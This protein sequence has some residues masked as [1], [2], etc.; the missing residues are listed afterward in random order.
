MS[1][2]RENPEQAV[3]ALNEAAEYGELRRILET[4]VV[5]ICPAWLAACRDDLV[6][7]ALI[8]VMRVRRRGEESG[9]LASSYLWRVAHSA[10]VDEIRRR[11][12]RREDPLDETVKNTEPTVAEPDPERRALGAELGQAIRDCLQRMVRPRRLAVTLH[13]QGHTVPETATLLGWER[14]RAENLVYRGLKNLRD[15]LASMGLKP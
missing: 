11:R 7:A 8:K 9:E 12:R 2:D 10:L 15:C 3:E 13:L 5:R 1:E 14:K 6:Q 4:A